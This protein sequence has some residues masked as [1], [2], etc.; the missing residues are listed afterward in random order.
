MKNIEHSSLLPIAKILGISENHRLQNRTRLEKTAILLNVESAEAHLFSVGFSQWIRMIERAFME[1]GES[2][3]GE[4]L[5]GIINQQ[6]KYLYIAFDQHPLIICVKNRL[7]EKTSLQV[8]SFNDRLCLMCTLPIH[9]L[10]AEILAKID[11]I[12]Q[13]KSIAELMNEL[14]R[15]NEALKSF[16][17][18]LEKAIQERTEDLN[19]AKEKA[20][21]ATKAK[22]MFLANMSHEIRTPMNA[23]IGLSHLALKTNLNDQQRDYVS[24]IH[25][26]G[27]SLL[28]IINDILDFSKI[29]AG[30]LELE[31]VDFDLQ[32][33]LDHLATMM[34]Q[35]VRD[36]NLELSFS[37]DQRLPN[38]LLGDPL[39]L[40]QV[41]INLLNN[42]VKFTHKG[43]VVLSIKLL[44][45]RDLHLKIGVEVKDTGIGMNES[46]RRKLFQPFLQADGSTT[47]RFGGTGLGLTIS[48]R[49]VQMMGGDIEVESTEGVGSVFKFWIWVDEDLNQEKRS[50]AMPLE[51]Q[52]FRALIVEDMPAAAEVLASLLNRF[53]QRVE[54]VATGQSALDVVH[55]ANATQ[56]DYDWI[57]LDWKLPDM[58]GIDVLKQ[59]KEERINS[60]LIMVTAYGD[61]NMRKIAQDL[62]A[63]AVLFKPISPSSL[64]DTMVSL[65]YQ[66]QKKNVKSKEMTV[67]EVPEKEPLQGIRLLL[68]EDHEINR[69]I[70]QELLEG[71]GAQVEIA[72][73]G[74]EA[75]DFMKQ[76]ASEVDLVLMDIQMP[77]MDGH[78]ATTEIRQVLKLNL[79]ILAMTA[80]A[81]A[82]EKERCL[83][84][85]MNDHL[86]KPIDSNKL[87][88][89]ILHW[90]RQS[91]DLTPGDAPIR[92]KQDLPLPQILEDEPEEIAVHQPKVP[93]VQKPY[94]DLPMT[95]LSRFILNT[96]PS[97][98][99]YHA[100]NKQEALGLLNHN[101]NLYHKLIK[102]FV[103]QLINF[104]KHNQSLYGKIT[105][106]TVDEEGRII[107]GF[108][109]TLDDFMRTAHSYKGLAAQLGFGQFSETAAEIEHTLKNVIKDQVISQQQMLLLLQLEKELLALISG[110]IISISQEL[111]ETVEDPDPQMYFQ[112]IPSMHVDQDGKTAM[113]EACLESI[114][115]SPVPQLSE[116]ALSDEQ[117]GVLNQLEMMA[118]GFDPGIVDLFKANEGFLREVFGH[119][120]AILEALDDF[121]FEVFLE[122]L[123]KFRG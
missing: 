99:D 65:S 13:S 46:Q 14:T 59:L 60:K 118:S 19:V 121:Q 1:E 66:G 85:G 9:H 122:A 107:D 91:R 67:V 58:D 33:V 40:G 22:S 96:T 87:I 64:V 90:V 42:A 25:Y 5:I 84:N 94:Q 116:N 3:S 115:L 41:L 8:K 52:E 123:G 27:T 50:T 15:K 78:Q 79:P 23:I 34:H 30:R 104:I 69:Q 77:I 49:L 109:K 102:K 88:K 28:G 70:A 10:S 105:L 39:R 56:R 120:D 72:C 54:K 101:E 6:T 61:E 48:Q 47:R 73:D 2:F 53:T 51:M 44:E 74:K 117:R 89:T 111:G 55:E 71:A 95:N 98:A 86:T 35:S 26:A 80:H 17:E 16:S 113:D 76:R 110:A 43:E 103:T 20:E 29:E 11:E 106:E 108:Y 83:K 112:N 93:A 4:I 7:Q 82:E 62:G 92:K 21:E 57:F 31:K 36:K 81:M 68:V 75:V 119:Y 97:P 45:K 38:R 18:D 24:K 114:P 63:D 32:A 37:I 100:F 12:W